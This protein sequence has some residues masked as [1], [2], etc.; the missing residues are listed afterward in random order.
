MKI[1]IT[2]ET[3]NNKKFLFDLSESDED[4]GLFFISSMSKNSNQIYGYHTYE[5]IDK[6]KFMLAVLK[7][8]ITF[9]IIKD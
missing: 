7:H 2:T 4:V 1:K 6:H 9:E 5:V 8:E 3:F